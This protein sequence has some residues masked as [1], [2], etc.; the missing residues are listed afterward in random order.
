M[1]GARLIWVLSV[2][3][4]IAAGQAG[5]VPDAWA[6]AALERA[7]AANAQIS[8]S[9][10]RAQSLAE[11]AEAETAIGAIAPARESIRQARELSAQIKVEPLASWIVHD[12][13]MAQVKAG[14]L[15]DAEKTASTIKDDRLQDAVFGAIV[16]SRRSGGGDLDLALATARRMSLP[17]NQGRTLREIAIVQANRGDIDGALA[18]ARSIVHNVFNALALGDV[19]VVAARVGNVAEARQLA[20]RIRDDF[21]RAR[22]LAEIVGVQA[23]AGQLGSAMSIAD[24]IEDKLQRAGALGSIAAARAAGGDSRGAGELFAQAL[25]AIEAGRGAERKATLFAEVA[26]AQ[27]EAGDRAGARESLNKA[28]EQVRTVRRDD[29]RLGLL[30]SIAP[31]QARAGDFSGAFLTASQTGDPSLR[32]LL[33][34]D[35][36][37]AQA[38]SGDPSGA[39]VAARAM[40][41]PQA[42]AAACFGVVRVLAPGRNE[43]ALR[44]ALDAAHAALRDIRS[45]EV[46]SGF[47]GS[48]AVAHVKAGDDAGGA[49]TFE[50]AM[51]VAE[52]ADPGLQKATAYARIAD[53]VADRSL[54]LPE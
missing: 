43:A 22:A 28:L 21:Y 6:R 34:R 52:E 37:V 31:L 38:E 16:D 50:E 4:A 54:A 49:S 3:P 48:L 23:D 26:R 46:R 7:H 12:V 32:P 13:A 10:H 11:I 25:A 33:A 9:Y 2:L 41:D 39:L 45:V 36:A 20:A 1:T 5:A 27:L 47:L 30:S 35:I 19:A 44:D 40:S 24:E 8:D 18:T 42:S 17:A 14:E 29:V 51:A 15:A 53:A